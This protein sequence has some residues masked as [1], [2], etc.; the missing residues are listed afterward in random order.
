MELS[1]QWNEKQPPEVFF[2]K[3]ILK[4]FMKFTGK[5][6]CQGLFFYKVALEFTKFLR[7][8]LFI[9]H[10]RWLLPKNFRS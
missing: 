4:N 10:L 5:H 2:K 7:P 8:P 1:L 9:E 3:G 6:L